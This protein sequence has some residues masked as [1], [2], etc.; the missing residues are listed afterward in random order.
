MRAQQPP[1]KTAAPGTNTNT[2]SNTS[3]TNT[4]N[5]NTSQVPK[6]ARVRSKAFLLRGGSLKSLINAGLLVP[7]TGVLSVEYKSL[8]A[9]ADLTAEGQIVYQGGWVA[10]P[11]YY[12]HH[13]F[14]VFSTGRRGWHANVMCV[15][16]DLQ[17]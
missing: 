16:G 2:T 12:Y 9:L 11:Y 14:T 3:N 7:G 6:T 13:Y 1:H 8:L 15:N 4:T 17:M 10:L 5:S